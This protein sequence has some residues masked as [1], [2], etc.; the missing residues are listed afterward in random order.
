MSETRPPDPDAE[1]EVDLRSAWARITAR[2]WLPVAG[3]V[4]GAVLGVLVSVGGGDVFR[5]TALLYL[6]SRSRP[7]AAGRSRASRRTPRP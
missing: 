6:G 7:R 4:V 5:A 3:L 2:W 1:R